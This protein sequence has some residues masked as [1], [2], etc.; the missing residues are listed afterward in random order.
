MLWQG[1][2]SI[3]NIYTLLLQAMQ[4]QSVQTQIKKATDHTNI[5]RAGQRKETR[6]SK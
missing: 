4:L 6:N 3:Q 2:H 5:C 1:I